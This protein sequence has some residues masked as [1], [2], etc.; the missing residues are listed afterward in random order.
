[1]CEPI[2]SSHH[3]YIS[4]ETT[5]TCP[6]SGFA[7]DVPVSLASMRQNYI[8]DYPDPAPHTAAFRCAAGIMTAS[9]DTLQHVHISA[10]S[11]DVVRQAAQIK[12]A[13]TLAFSGLEIPG[14][15]PAA[16]SARDIL[17]ACESNPADAKRDIVLLYGDNV[18]SEEVAQVRRASLVVSSATSRVSYGTFA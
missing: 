10:D 7:L 2:V 4:C 18:T 8:K 3:T 14:S 12:G 17:S 6:C 5:N 1:M 13:T 16:I 15:N 11:L 9:A